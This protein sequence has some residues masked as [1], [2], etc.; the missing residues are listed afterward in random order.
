MNINYGSNKPFKPPPLDANN[1]RPIGYLFRHFQNFPRN[2]LFSNFRCIGKSSLD[3]LRGDLDFA[4]LS[5]LILCHG[6]RSAEHTIKT[7]FSISNKY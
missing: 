4:A 7:I 3:H 1:I 5:L 6:I 2:Q